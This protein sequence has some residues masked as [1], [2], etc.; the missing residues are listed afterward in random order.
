MLRHMRDLPAPDITGLLAA[1]GDGN[2][3]ALDRVVAS[4]YPEMRRIARRQ[5][6]RKSDEV[7]LESGVL[8]NEAYLKLIRAGGIECVSRVHFLALCAQMVRHILVDHARNRGYAKRGG[9][10]VMVTLNEAMH[11]G[12]MKSIEL[13]A[14]DEAL[15]ALAQFDE[16]KSKVVELRYFGGLSV[17]DAAEVLNISPET[18]KRDWKTAKAWLLAALSAKQTELK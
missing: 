2:R 1:W 5:L 14:L 9:G 3:E 11:G 17:E 8:V 13:L 6:N 16:R 7:S 12:N 4:L 10:A 18:A 15:S